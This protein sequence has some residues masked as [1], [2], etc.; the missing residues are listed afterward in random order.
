MKEMSAHVL[1]FMLTFV[2]MKKKKKKKKTKQ[3]NNNNKQI[4]QRAQILKSEDRA[5]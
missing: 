5:F 1:E 4:L 3:K 2:K